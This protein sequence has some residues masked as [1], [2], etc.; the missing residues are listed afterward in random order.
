MRSALLFPPV[1]LLACACTD[2]Q[3]TPPPSGQTPGITVPEPPGTT[4]A[5]ALE[6]DLDP[7]VDA[8][9]VAALTA[10]N[11]GF[12][13]DLYRQL[14][15]TAGNLFVSPHSVSVALAMTYAGAMGNTKSEMATAMHFRLPEPSLHQA[16]NAL[17]LELASRAQAPTDP[18]G[19]GFQLSVVNQLF[20]Q[21]GFSF[22][23]PF[24]DLLARQYGA[25]LRLLDFQEDPEGSREQINTWVEE[26]TEDRIEDL[27]PEGSID[28]A[29]RLV[30]ANAIY[31]KA[32][33]SLPF[34]PSATADDAFRRLD[35]STVT[36]PTMHGT[37]PAGYA[38]GDGWTLVEL[39]YL[40]EQVTM[41]LMVPDAERFEEVEAAIDGPFLDEAIGGLG[42][43][44]VTLA[45][46]KFSFRNAY[47]LVP[48]MMELGMID[49]FGG[50]D[51]SAMSTAADLVITGIF[52]QAFVEVNEEGTEAA[53]ATAVVV[54][55]TSVPPTFTVSVDRPFLFWIRDVPTGAMLFTGRV[56]DPSGSR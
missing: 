1:L 27:L 29:T 52:H 35:G 33:W 46:P 34:E 6:R 5:S 22:E 23:Q 17:D 51:F 42:A 40:G 53:A 25:G 45:M 7:D 49:A 50:A 21:T 43:A 44:Q 18:D 2:V 28:P 8:A 16:F 3:T 26:V 20:G 15:P 12:A 39:P 31:F 37:V 13:F 4:V 11:R 48:P 32:S 14:A 41:G 24:L 9:T 36:V 38:A 10:D 19:D 30:L 54:G 47:D 56:V 55:E